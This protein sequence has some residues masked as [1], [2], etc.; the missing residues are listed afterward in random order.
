MVSKN[1][2]ILQENYLVGKKV[3]YTVVKSFFLKNASEKMVI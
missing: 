3:D 1:Y 2:E